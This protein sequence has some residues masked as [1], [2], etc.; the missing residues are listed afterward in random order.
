MNF[1]P[2]AG[3]PRAAASSAMRRDTAAVVLAT[4]LAGAICGYLELS[5]RVFEATRRWEYLQLDELPAVLLVLAASL[6]WYA[7]RRYRESADELAR[8]TEA[9]GRLTALLHDHRRLAQQHIALQEAER[10][11]LARELHDEA[12][13]YLNAIKTDAVSMQ[14]RYEQELE[15]VRRASA[16]IIEHT[17]RVYDVVRSLIR[18]LRPVG[19]DDLGLKAAL[20]HHTAHWRQRLPH[21]RLTV[22]LDGELDT[23]GE[24]LSLAIYRL[25][26]EGLTNVARHAQ[27]QRVE[28]EVS[29][30]SATSGPAEEVTVRLADDGCGADLLRQRTGVGLVSMRERAEMLDGELKVL[31]EPSRGFVILARLPIVTVPV[32]VSG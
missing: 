4:A 22:S 7:W 17:D 24:P 27:A 16:S 18:Q 29:R 28:L 1:I 8:R 30:R 19:L 15:P 11:H 10:K 25:V 2:E 5:E 13:Q 3:A 21:V 9:E 6:V 12:G 23:L 26:Q 14:R 31:S 20:E 32:Q